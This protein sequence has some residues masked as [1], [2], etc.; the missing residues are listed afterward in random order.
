MKPMEL[1]IQESANSL[2]IAQLITLLIPSPSSVSSNALL[3]NKPMPTMTPKDATRSALMVHS[4]I[5]QLTPVSSYA[6]HLPLTLDMIISVLRLA[7]MAL[8]PI[9]LP[10]YA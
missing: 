7:L 2:L 3:L 9:I 10:D 6:L 1:R 8:M 4:P 5:I